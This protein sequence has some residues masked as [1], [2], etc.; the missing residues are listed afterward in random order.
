L[1]YLDILGLLETR[2]SM[3][4]QYYQNGELSQGLTLAELKNRVT[5]DELVKDETGKWQA[6]EKLAGW[7]N[8]EESTMPIQATDISSVSVSSTEND[9]PELLRKVAV[10]S[11]VVPDELPEKD[12]F[13]YQQ[14]SGFGK[15]FSYD[16]EYISGGTYLG[17]MVLQSFLAPL[18]GIGLYL[19]TVT[20][21][22]RARSL[23]A[24]EGSGWVAFLMIVYWIV[25]GNSIKESANRYDAYY[26][27]EP[28]TN[29][30]LG[31]FSLFMVVLHWWLT[32]KNSREIM[33]GGPKALLRSLRVYDPK[34]RE[35][36]LKLLDREQELRDR[37]D[38][39]DE[40]M[41]VPC[42][43][44]KKGAAA[45]QRYFETESYYLAVR[46]STRYYALPEINDVVK[47]SKLIKK[48]TDT[49]KEFEEFKK[50]VSF[51]R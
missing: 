42:L 23:G 6:A 1:K 26:G 10:Q 2:F 4:Y 9:T 11:D 47:P 3:R 5:P 28:E 19:I 49:T 15:Y 34:H 37:N 29:I 38:I 16:N 43:I 46:D 50:L 31:L 30:A 22:K 7:D 13:K 35:E 45:Y 51:K 8:V 12:N 44:P 48:T 14:P 39:P 20:T 40:V 36:L 33:L 27:S 32:L 21:Y 25:Y 41:V 24:G 17:R 18:L